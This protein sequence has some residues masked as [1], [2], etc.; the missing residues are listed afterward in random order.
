MPP[1]A[2]GG[3]DRLL[4]HHRSG[5]LRAVCCVLSANDGIVSTA[6]LVLGA[7]AAGADHRTVLLTDV[8]GLISDAMSIT[9]GEFVSIRSQQNAKNADLARDRA[10]LKAEPLGEQCG[11]TGIHVSRGRDGLLADQVAGDFHGARRNR[12][13][14]TRRIGLFGHYRHSPH[15]GG[16]DEDK[17]QAASQP[18]PAIGNQIVG[19]NKALPHKRLQSS[20]SIL[21][22]CRG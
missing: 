10:E 15:A 8:F 19:C 18:S 2:D 14:R 5:W 6:S 4:E 1:L 7:A 16:K 9:V 12:R 13:A 21:A 11:L 22:L 3:A 17:V 20:A